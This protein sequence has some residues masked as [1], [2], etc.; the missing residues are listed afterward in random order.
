MIKRLNELDVKQQLALVANEHR[1]DFV[2]ALQG[3]LHEKGIDGTGKELKPYKN[4]MVEDNGRL[5]NYPDLKHEMNPAVGYGNPD[6]FYTGSF[7]N[8]MY[9]DIAADGTVQLG[10]TDSKE[11]SLNA[12]YGKAIEQ[13]A[14]IT[15][16]ELYNT[17]LHPDLVQS[18]K[19]QTGIQ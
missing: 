6:L 11:D 5:I 12:K 14:P 17:T 3:Q 1:D 10:S 15:A 7:Y 19:Q 16:T 2:H 9:A 4:F 8:S 13:L 18:V